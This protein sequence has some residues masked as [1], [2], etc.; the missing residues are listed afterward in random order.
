MTIHRFGRQAFGLVLA[1]ASL[2]ACGGRSATPG[3]LPQ[4]G[5]QAPGLTPNAATM[6]ARV[7]RASG[8][9]GDLLYVA[10]EF[11][12]ILILRYPDLAKVATI[13]VQ[14][15]D[16]NGCVDSATGDVYFQTYTT[17]TGPALSEYPIGGTTSIGSIV[18]PSGYYFGPCA[19]DPTTGNIAVI[20]RKLGE[21]SAGY[22]AVYLSATGQR[23]T[24]RDPALSSYNSCI[25]DPSGNLFVV[26]NGRSSY[27]PVFARLQKG[28]RNFINLSTTAYL[29]FGPLQW[30]GKYLISQQYFF[31]RPL[32]VYR[33][34]IS[35]KQAKGVGTALLRHAT[36]MAWI[37]G[38]TAIA[39][40]SG[41]HN[42]GQVAF[43]A[44]PDGGKAMRRTRKLP[45]GY[46]WGVSV[47][48]G[49]S[50]I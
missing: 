30:H 32:S 10:S 12:G 42:E 48:H 34:S 41:N 23:Q 20:T 50:R 33:I 46:L 5:A 1:A 17:S 8:S 35:G 3:T 11:N 45:L 7:H 9:S 19:V 4:G 2:A 40:W 29:G 22:I 44:Y 47:I 14:E 38:N 16:G 21:R 28:R 37:L 36:Q 26:G 18:P 25:Y 31:K 39:V 43:Y 49:P 6:Q 24:H 27:D 15:V 13:S